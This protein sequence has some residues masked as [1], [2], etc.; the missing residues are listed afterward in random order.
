VLG[1]LGGVLVSV[2]F[3]PRRLGG[4]V[5]LRRV[6]PSIRPADRCLI[7]IE[8]WQTAVA[9]RER[10]TLVAGRCSTRPEGPGR[11]HAYV[12]RLNTYVALMV[13]T[14]K[15]QKKAV[16]SVNNEK[17]PV[18]VLRAPRTSIGLL[19]FGRRVHSSML[20]NPSFPSPNPPLAVFAGHLDELEDAET[21]AATRAKG[22]GAFRDVKAKRVNDDLFH[23]RAYVQSIVEAAMT[24]VEATAV[25]ESASMSVRKVNT[26]SLPEVQ[27]KNA[28]VSGKV[29][30]VAKAVAPAA[31]YSW[32][33]TLD[34]SKWSSVPDTMKSRT[35]LSGLT[36][37]SMYYFRFRTFTRTGRQDYSQV[38][39]LLVH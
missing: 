33:Y 17:A 38:V 34:P 31:V 15:P 36:P 30:L 5:A 3:L 28:E 37:G 27:A 23:L 18:P 14:K 32:E 35:E 12:E 7:S 16:M 39:S 10:S 11:T 26:P 29:K 19:L 6:A 4:S 8:L 13:G 22:A 9:H 2:V 24:P 21:K 20:N 25:I 1:R